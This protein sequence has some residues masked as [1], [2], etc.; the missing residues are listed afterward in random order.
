MNGLPILMTPKLVLFA[1]GVAIV[2]CYLMT[3][4][5]RFPVVTSSGGS[6]LDFLMLPG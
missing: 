6:L 4:F 2:L 5:M 3:L 1:V